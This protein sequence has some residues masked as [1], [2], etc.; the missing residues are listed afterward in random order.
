[1]APRPDRTALSQTFASLGIRTELVEALAKRGITSPFDIQ[2]LT[3]RDAIAG[4]DVCGQA[5]TGSGKTLAF[6]LPL[7]QRLGEGE[8]TRHPRGLILVPTRELASQVVEELIPLGE[9]I[10]LSVLA[11]YGGVSLG[12]Q[13]DRLDKGVDVIVATP[14]RLVDL[15]ERKMTSLQDVQ[16]AIVDEADRMSDIGFL[17]PVDWILR[18]MRAHRPQ[19]LLFSATLDS[20]VDQLVQ[21]HL[22]DPVRF[23]VEFS[24]DGVEEMTHRFLA[25]HPMDRVKVAATIAK[26]VERTIIF[27]RTKRGADRVAEDLAAEGLAT[28]AIH[29]DLA[30]PVR[31]KALKKF[32][33][34]KIK[35][36]VATDVAARGIHVDDIDIVIHFDPPADHK[37]YLHRSGR[38]ARAGRTGIVATFVLWDQKTEVDRLKKRLGLDNEPTVTVYSTDSRLADLES[39]HEDSASVS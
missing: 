33:D 38:T 11:V 31:E 4:R 34:G 37:D 18:Q 3:I 32:S 19:T 17:P 23:A 20:V 14:G 27:T 25:V 21:R 8:H 15:I 13:G 2:S 6:G 12:T 9:A 22:A 1:V 29:G 26:T 39:M 28:A 5:K 30:Q 16:M 36:L 24:D 10:G 7:L 35:V